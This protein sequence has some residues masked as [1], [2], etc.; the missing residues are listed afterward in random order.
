MAGS[1]AKDSYF[2]HIFLYPLMHLKDW[3]ISYCIWICIC[4]LAPKYRWFL[5]GFPS[6]FKWIWRFIWESEAYLF[7]I[8]MSSDTSDYSVC[9]RGRWRNFTEVGSMDF[10][11]CCTCFGFWAAWVLWTVPSG[12][13]WDFWLVTIWESFNLDHLSWFGIYFGLDQW[14]FSFWVGFSCLP[15]IVVYWSMLMV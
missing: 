11:C 8:C 10:T 1:W 2:N 13:H 12:L 15:I 5:Y 4:N 7:R 14:N 3:S 6:Q 9:V